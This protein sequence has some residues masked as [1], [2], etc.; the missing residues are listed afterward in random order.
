MTKE[1]NTT[2][3]GKLSFP[4]DYVIRFRDGIIGFPDLKEY[5]FIESTTMPLVLW[6]QS[7]ED[8]S[9]AFPLVEPQLFRKDYT[10]S[11]NHA[12]DAMISIKPE[13]KLKAF[14][15]MTIPA[16]VE[17]MSVNLRAP[18]IVNM[19]ESTAGQIILQDKTLALRENVFKEFQNA[20]D[21]LAH[22]ELSDSEEPKWSA[23]NWKEDA[24]RQHGGSVPMTV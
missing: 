21:S 1:I 6:L 5:V 9:V 18:V 7:T 16:S 12:D 8:A 2:R 11:L 17:H 14:L 24:R 4:T 10:Y 13:S 15:I 3:F 20:M 19:T 23:H 22:F